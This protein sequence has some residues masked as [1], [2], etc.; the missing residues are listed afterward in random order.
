[1]PVYSRVKFKTEHI[2]IFEAFDEFFML[3]ENAIACLAF[4]RTW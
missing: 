3:V 4:L 2:I 1:M